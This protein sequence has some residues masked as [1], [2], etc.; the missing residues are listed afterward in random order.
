MHPQEL[1]ID[2][3]AQKDSDAMD[4]VS[5]WHQIHQGN[6]VLTKFLN[7]EPMEPGEREQLDVFIDL[8]RGRLS[9]ISWYMRVLN[10]KV[11]RMPM[12]KMMSSGRF[13]EGRFKCQALLD[14]QALLSCM[15]YV[16]LNPVRAAIAATPEQSNHTSIQHRIRHW[17]HHC[18]ESI[19]NQET[20]PFQPKD[21]HPF[22]GNLRQEIPK[23]IIYNLIDYLELVDWTG[24]QIREDKVSSISEDAKPTL[25]RL[26]ISPEHWVYLCTNFESR[27]KELVGS[28]HS[29]E[30][31]CQLFNR[32]RRPNLSASI[33]IFA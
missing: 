15:A 30:K 1:F 5:R 2:Q 24:R 7:Q 17:K 9:S 31:A 26:A 13:W 12:L 4:L 32:K 11:A 3:Q 27:F 10:E 16:D 22:A 33:E 28:V 21:L 20:H 23:G 14:E 8:W 18:C 29:L 25:E 6:M 19:T